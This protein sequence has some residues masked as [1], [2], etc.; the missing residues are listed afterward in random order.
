MGG[1]GGEIVERIGH[2]VLETRGLAKSL[3]RPVL[4]AR[5][6]HGEERFPAL[7]A[8]Q[9]VA[10][11]AA[12]ANGADGC[13]GLDAALGLRHVGHVTARRTDAEGTDAVRI[14]GVRRP[15]TETFWPSSLLPGCS[16]RA[17]TRTAEWPPSR[18]STAYPIVAPCR[19]LLPDSTF[20]SP[21]VELDLAVANR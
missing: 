2:H 13:H 8:G 12:Q 20:R 6:E 3:L 4:A 15:C 19:L 5:F 7:A 21:K 9:T 16:R 10:E 1:S 18:I 14:Q 17:E 11:Q